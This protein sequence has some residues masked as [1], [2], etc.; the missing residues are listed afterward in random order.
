MEKLN[1][2][3]PQ[4]NN[5]VSSYIAGEHKGEKFLLHE[6]TFYQCLMDLCAFADTD[7]LVLMYKIYCAGYDEGYS[8]AY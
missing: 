4:L 3:N 7:T 5:Y 8:D 1:V 2:D 6:D